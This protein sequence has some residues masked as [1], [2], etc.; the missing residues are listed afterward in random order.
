MSSDVEVL[1]AARWR[2]LKAVRKGGHIGLSE[3]ILYDTIRALFPVQVTH[4]WLRDQLDYLEREGLLTIDQHPARPWDVHLT[5]DGYEYVDYI[6]PV[7]PGV[8]RPPAPH[9]AD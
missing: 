2:V 5:D 8:A 7:R 1:R 9:P 4:L 3:D 6:S